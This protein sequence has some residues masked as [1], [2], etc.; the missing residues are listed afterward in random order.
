M[1]CLRSEKWGNSDEYNPYD[2]LTQI[3]DDIDGTM[4]YF[5]KKYNDD[6]IELSF[7]AIL[8]DIRHCL[9]KIGEHFY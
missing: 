3:Y 7:K 6:D 5:A 9:L 2:A 4:K 8:E 1:D